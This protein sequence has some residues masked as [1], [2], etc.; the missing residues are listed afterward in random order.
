MKL[1][2]SIMRETLISVAAHDEHGKFV[3]RLT[4]YAEGLESTV[5]GDLSFRISSLYVRPDA[6][7]QGI[8]TAL[9]KFA[10]EREPRVRHSDQLTSDGA[11]F[12]RSIEADRKMAKE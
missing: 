4:W 7:R 6:R 10:Q 2:V 3:G 11:K 9:F 12:V 5:H 1:I 8:A